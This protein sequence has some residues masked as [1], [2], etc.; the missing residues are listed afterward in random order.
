MY[1]RYTNSWK[2]LSDVRLECMA[3]FAY[4]IQR[5]RNVAEQREG[6]LPIN[7]AVYPIACYPL[8]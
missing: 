6:L 4:A 1:G 5:V 3:I 2:Q 8:P 7:A